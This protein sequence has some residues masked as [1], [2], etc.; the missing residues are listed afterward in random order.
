MISRPAILNRYHTEDDRVD[1]TAL[2]DVLFTLM[3]FLIL[4]MGAVQVSTEIRLAQSPL[5]PSDGSRPLLQPIVVE[6]N[7]PDRSWKIADSVFYSSDQ[8]QTE[9]IQR[10]ETERH[11]PLL[12]LVAR[13][14][15][16]ED[17][18]GLLNFFSFHQFDH[19]QLISEWRP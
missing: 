9:F 13:S 17:L 10:F 8:F 14:L 7:H 6:V 16:T 19:V 5:K 11:R 3:I 2:I 1:M 15:P 4:T 12:L 18:I